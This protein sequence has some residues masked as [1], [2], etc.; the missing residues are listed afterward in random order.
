M[1]HI[2]SAS[3]YW[4]QEKENELYDRV[5]KVLFADTKITNMY[6]EDLLTK[7]S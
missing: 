1:T 2:E 6:L 7:L 3:A 5:Q 4:D